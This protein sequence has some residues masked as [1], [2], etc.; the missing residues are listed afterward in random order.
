MDS[1]VIFKTS[2]RDDRQRPGYDHQMAFELLVTFLLILLN[3]VFAGAEISIISLRPSRARQLLEQG[4]PGAAAVI[5]LQR[6]PERFLATVQI[7]I[8]VVGATAAAFSGAA[9]AARLSPAL[10]VLGISPQ[11][12]HEFA[13][14][15]VVALVSY[16][17]L[18][19]GELVPKSLALRSGE[20]YALFVARP[21]RS[22][23]SLMRP[24]V[25]FLTK[26]SNV[27]LRPFGDATSFMEARVSAEEL[28]DMLDKAAEAG[29]LETGSGEMASRAIEFGSLTAGDVM[30]PR[31]HVV[32]IPKDAPPQEVQRLLLEHGHTRMPVYEGSLD[33]VV[34]YVTTTDVLALLLERDLL[35][36]EDIIR[37]PLFVPETA[38]ATRVLH[39]LRSQRLWMA[40]VVDEHGG[41][42]GLV[43]VE[44]LIEEVVGEL[45]SERETPPELIRQEGDGVAVVRGDLP[46]REANRQLDLDLPE[47]DGWSTVAGLCVSLAGGIPK[48]GA[49]VRAN[50]VELEVLEAG[51]RAVRLVRIRRPTRPIAD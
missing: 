7:G 31:N 33:N 34:G 40:V 37:P 28:R 38:K 47:G 30:V 26:S 24:L 6:D 17:S 16:L 2:E 9:I 19:F 27:V 44:D 22:L 20:I 48:P 29:E 18:V 42:A 1:I 45:F 25:W 41:V 13:L 11:R 4:R 8:T 32:A 39:D 23:A 49:R 46:I 36:I 43:T 12:A 15:L 14:A 10:T 21:L 3:G 35:V 51:P 50:D 5:A